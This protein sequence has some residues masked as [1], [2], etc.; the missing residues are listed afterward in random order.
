MATAT[1]KDITR[2]NKRLLKELPFYGVNL[3][4]QLS[5][6]LD[7]CL[8]TKKQLDCLTSIYDLDLFSL[9]KQ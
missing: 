4:S 9:I 5:N 8:P 6:N 1:L 7:G 3:I 2:M